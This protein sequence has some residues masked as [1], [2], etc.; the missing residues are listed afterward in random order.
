MNISFNKEVKEELIQQKVS[1]DE[2]LAELLAFWSLAT[3]KYEDTYVFFTSSLSIARRFISNLNNTIKPVTKVTKYQ[4]DG[5]VKVLVELL[6]SNELLE[7]CVLKNDFDHFD[8]LLNSDDLKR[9]FLRAV[10]LTSGSINSPYSLKYHLE[11]V[12]KN[13]SLALFIQRVINYFDSNCKITVRKKNYVI[14][15]KNSTG[16][17]YFLFLIGANNCAYK[18][19]D[20]IIR[21]DMIASKIRI[22]N[23]GVA[24]DMKTINSASKQI[25]II[26]EIYKSNAT[27]LLSEELQNIIKCRKEN[28]TLNLRELTTQYNLI[29]GTSISRTTFNRKLN[30]ALSIKENI[31]D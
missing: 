2:M 4:S 14:Y 8:F 15:L 25:A 22:S 10:F 18:L 27:H 3:K 23:V 7:R 31:I 26:D 16:I 6:D 1:T 9:S 20:E 21:R 29:Y 12:T 30:K 19:E 28:N 11:I 5:K 17:S 13:S 24:N